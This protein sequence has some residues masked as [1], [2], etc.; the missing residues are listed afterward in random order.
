MPEQL[1]AWSD[2]A[3]RDLVRDGTTGDADEIRDTA[4]AQPLL[5][6][7]A[8]AAAGRCSATSRRHGGCAAPSPAIA[9]ANSRQARSRA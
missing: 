7:A 2:L 6:A 5:A 1:A 9:S 8:M 4:T 3:G